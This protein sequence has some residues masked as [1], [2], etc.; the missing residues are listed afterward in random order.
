ME[1]NRQ[2]MHGARKNAWRTQAAWANYVENMDHLDIY[3]IKI[4]KC[5][6]NITI[7]IIK[8]CSRSVTDGS[9]KIVSGF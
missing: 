6:K 4:K 8:I 1:N 7:V 5:Y 3:L 2:A 9:A